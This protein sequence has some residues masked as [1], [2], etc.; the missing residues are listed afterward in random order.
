MAT[1]LTAHFTLEEL[2]A[3]QHRQFDND[4]PPPVRAELWRTAA[5]MEVVRRLLGDRVISVSSGYRCPELNRA[6]GGA[7]T[8]AHLQGLAIDFNAYAFGPP[9]EVCRPLAKSRLPF[10]QPIEEAG[11]THTSCDPRVRS[12]ILTQ[13]ARGYREGIS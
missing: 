7:A 9:I 12:E 6:V 10:D 11:W 2:T 5:Q 8:S 3:T 13:S 1:W 4:P